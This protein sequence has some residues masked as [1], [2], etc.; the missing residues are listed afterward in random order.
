M[1]NKGQILRELISAHIR[2]D[3]KE[4]AERIIRDVSRSDPELA[5]DLAH[6]MAN[7]EY[8]KTV[9]AEGK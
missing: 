3:F 6:I 9:L 2:G 8:A 4:V 1:Y 7:P 5:Y